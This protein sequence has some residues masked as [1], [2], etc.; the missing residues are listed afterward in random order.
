MHKILISPTFNE[1][2]SMLCIYKYMTIIFVFF[3]NEV[4]VVGRFNP[5]I[6]G[7]PEYFIKS[8]QNLNKIT[9]LF[10]VIL[11]IKVLNSILNFK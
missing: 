2:L 7:K 3:F 5:L 4:L 6:L 10:T 1:F 11:L 9:Y 8:I